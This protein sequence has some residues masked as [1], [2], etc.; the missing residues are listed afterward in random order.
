MIESSNFRVLKNILIH[1]Y[2][3][4]VENVNR[5]VEEYK[6]FVNS[7]VDPEEV[8]EMIYFYETL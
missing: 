8:A 6:V 5:I 1:K 4:S 7:N 3:M 2:K